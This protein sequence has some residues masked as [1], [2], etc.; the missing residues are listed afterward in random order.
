[1]TV[2]I[3][4]VAGFGIYNILSMAINHKRREIAILRSMGYE[5]GDIVE[6]FLIQGLILG[7]VGGV[8]GCIL[9]YGVCEIMARIPTAD[10]GLGGNHM[11]IVYFKGI[12]IRGFLLAFFS[13]SFAGFLP[14]RAA[15]KL[16]PIDIIRSENS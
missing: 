14:A 16:T 9:G 2:S 15:G 5:S 11:I 13:S 1:M 7:A 3:L 10:R 12:Y 8:A 4:I 6:L